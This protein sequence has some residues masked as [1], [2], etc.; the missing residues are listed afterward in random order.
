M[1]Q[2]FKRILAAAMSLLVLTAAVPVFADTG[3]AQLRSSSL[4]IS[5][6]LTLSSAKYINTS[7]N[8]MF[9]ENYYLCTP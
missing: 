6:Q 1:K 2:S 8:S 4:E 7:D 5:D 9:S 3:F